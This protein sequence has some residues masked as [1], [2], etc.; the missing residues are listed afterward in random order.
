MIDW[1][2]NNRQEFCRYAFGIALLVFSMSA[3]N[4]FKRYFDV[5]DDSP[6][7]EAIEDYIESETGID[8]DQTP[9]TTYTKNLKK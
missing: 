8:F 6:I 5:A 7:E 1:I 2:Y 9:C 4:E 3:C